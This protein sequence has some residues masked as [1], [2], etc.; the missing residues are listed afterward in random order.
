MASFA[1]PAKPSATHAHRAD[2]SVDT[3]ADDA[4]EQQQLPPPLPYDEPDWST[5]PPADTYS[6]EML[7]SG[8]MLGSVPLTGKRFFVI[9]RLPVCDIELE[10]AS[11][12]RY[13]CI[14]QYSSQG[15]WLL[16]DCSGH[17][18]LLNKTPIPK[19][20]HTRI[21]VGDQVRCGASTRLFVLQGPEDAPEPQPLDPASAEKAIEQDAEEEEKLQVSWGFGEDAVQDAWAG[22]QTDQYQIDEDAA[23]YKDPRKTLTTW[24]A[25]R[26]QELSFDFEEDGHGPNKQFIARLLVPMTSE[27]FDSLPCQGIASRKREAERI[28]CLEACA[29]LD[30]MH[31]LSGKTPGQVRQERMKALLG[32]KD[33]GDDDDSF[34]DRTHDKRADPGT[35]NNSGSSGPRIETYDT[36]LD[37]RRQLLAEI[38]ALEHRI[39]EVDR[40]TAEVDQDDDVDAYLAHLQARDEAKGRSATKHE[41][42]QSVQRLRK[43][44]AQV[45][46]LIKIAQPAHVTQ[47]SPASASPEIPNISAPTAVTVLPPASPTRPA[48]TPSRAG[49]SS[50]PAK[51]RRMQEPPQEQRDD[52]LPTRSPDVTMDMQQVA[53]DAPDEEDENW[54]PPTNQTGDGMTSLNAKY[55]Y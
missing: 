33:D 27:G 39:E 29:K 32:D 13:H 26:G 31:L 40:L 34:F 19:R 55:G 52:A 16:F 43:E 46:K 14:L 28:A 20:E 7:K 54:V 21:R 17:G 9:G 23:Y 11:I 22:A 35:K 49:P 2:A 8:V 1:V 6:L 5:L 12:S 25:N 37:K 10:H 24:L 15:H 41:M 4:R 3:P 44:V 42:R 45:D 30:A 36:L 53:E 50:P 51:R 18:T 47:A 38:A 48:A